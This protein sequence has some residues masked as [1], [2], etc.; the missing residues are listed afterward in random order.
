MVMAELAEGF[1]LRFDLQALVLKSHLHT[2]TVVTIE[3]EYSL[4]AYWTTSGHIDIFR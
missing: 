3:L 1:S 4:C 2:Q